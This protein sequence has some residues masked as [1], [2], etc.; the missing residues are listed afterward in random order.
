MCLI[1]LQCNDTADWHNGYPAA[2]NGLGYTCLD[3]VSQGWCGNGNFTAG[4]SG[5]GGANYKYPEDNCCA[6]SSQASGAGKSF[7]ES[8]FLLTF[9]L[10]GLCTPNPCQ[11]N[12]TCYATS[13]T[14]A[15]CDCTST[16]YTNPNC[17]ALAI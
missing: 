11:N 8:K 7:I 12:G 13:A 15:T 17:T 10:I 4:N 1:A 6:C 16:G 9:S 3:Y 5:T 2:N 14:T